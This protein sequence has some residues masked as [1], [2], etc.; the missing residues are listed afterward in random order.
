VWPY[1]IMCS[2]VLYCIAVR[3]IMLQT[4]LL[5]L[6]ISHFCLPL[7]LSLTHTL[8]HSIT[9]THT[10]F[11]ALSLLPPFPPLSVLLSRSRARTPFPSLPL[12]LSPTHTRT[13]TLPHDDIYLKQAE[14]MY[15]YR[16]V[17]R[18]PQCIAKSCVLSNALS[19]LT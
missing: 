19:G 18:R 15:A 7:S 1:V 11:R 16:R 13:H 3:C 2:S 5:L 4:H 8:T 9:H 17:K 6:S 14:I 10:L 12:S